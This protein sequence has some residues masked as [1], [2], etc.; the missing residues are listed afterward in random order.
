MDVVHDLT[1]FPWPFGD[2]RFEEVRMI[3]VLEHL[4]DLIRTMEEVWRVS[5]DGGR[6]M[7]RVPY[8]NCWQSIGDPTHLKRYHQ[9]S[10]DFCDPQRKQCRE[11]PYYT[12]ARFKITNIDYWF[13]LA[14]IGD[15]RGWVKISNGMVK[16][17]LSFLAMY[18]NN[19][20]WGLEFELI[21]L[22]EKAL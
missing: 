1:K 10:F 12:Q 8:W 13:P 15:G 4:P 18:L 21:V 9:Q 3:N 6:V 11:R 20:I 7:V 2:N 16:G 22:K 17:L 19:V 5:M 14:P